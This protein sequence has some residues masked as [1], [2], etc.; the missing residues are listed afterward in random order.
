VAVMSVIGGLLG[1]GLGFAGSALVRKHGAF[2]LVTVIVAE[3]LAALYDWPDVMARLA[4]FPALVVMGLVGQS[5]MKDQ[6]TLQGLFTACVYGATFGVTLFLRYTNGASLYR[7]VDDLRERFP[8]QRLKALQG[9]VAAAERR[10]SLALRQGSIS[11]ARG[12]AELARLCGDYRY[13][14]D[15]IADQ[16]HID[17][18]NLAHSEEVPNGYDLARAEADRVRDNFVL[19]ECSGGHVPTTP[20]PAS[21]TLP[22]ASP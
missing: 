1:W 19:P 22:P 20:A 15:D 16:L 12:N 13:R 14:R 11:P 2:P 3:G 17:L 6:V 7:I 5:T 9:D 4:G 8:D 21:P 10:W 18:L